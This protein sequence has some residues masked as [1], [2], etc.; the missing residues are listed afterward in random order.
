MQLQA[1]LQELG[2][3]MSC[4]SEFNIY[5][6]HEIDLEAIRSITIYDERWPIATFSMQKLCED[7]SAGDYTSWNELLG[8][9]PEIADSKRFMNFIQERVQSLVLEEKS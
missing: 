8:H 4:S 9:L 1:F 7:L 5:G 3:K 6:A 2:Q